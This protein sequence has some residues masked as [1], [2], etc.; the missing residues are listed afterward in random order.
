MVNLVFLSRAN[1]D[2]VLLWIELVVR[3]RKA[4]ELAELLVEQRHQLAQRATHLGVQ[5]VEL[6][7]LIGERPLCH[8]VLLRVGRKLGEYF[9]LDIARG[10]DEIANRLSPEERRIVVL[11]ASGQLGERGTHPPGVFSVDEC[12]PIG[13][14]R[15]LLLAGILSCEIAI[16]L[17]DRRIIW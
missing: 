10:A 5:Q 7:M 16:A 8:L 15:G 1:V 14:Q 4:V 2:A 17:L 13:G 12:S 3:K 11:L 6:P 9:L